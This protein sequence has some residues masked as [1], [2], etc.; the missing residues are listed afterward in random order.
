VEV[1]DADTLLVQAKASHIQA[2]Y[3]YRMAQTS[4]EQAIGLA[5]VKDLTTTME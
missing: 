5:A 3:D 4:I 2:L 1:T